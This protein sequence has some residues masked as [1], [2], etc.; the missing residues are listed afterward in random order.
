MRS[1][2]H[3]LQLNALSG[4]TRSALQHD[5]GLLKELQTHGRRAVRRRP[6]RSSRRSPAS[7]AARV[8]TL[9]MLVL[10]VYF[11]LPQFSDLPGIVDQVKEANWIWFVPVCWPRS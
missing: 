10:V 5:K 9:V 11:L 2:L 6:A 1:S 7:T 3:L 4:A 8:L